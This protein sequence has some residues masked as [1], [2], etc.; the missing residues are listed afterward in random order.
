MIPLTGVDED[1]SPDTI[2][3]LAPVFRHT[4]FQGKQIV[5]HRRYD[6]RHE[7][8]SYN[9]YPGPSAKKGIYGV[10]LQKGEEGD[11]L[12]LHASTVQAVTPYDNITTFLQQLYA[13]KT[14][15]NRRNLRGFYCLCS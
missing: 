13:R 5:V 10:L 6:R 14:K 15:R 12:T 2:I 11:W 3:Y 8:F 9:L 7:I 4:Y 1:F